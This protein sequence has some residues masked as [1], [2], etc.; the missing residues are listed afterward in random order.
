MHEK[1]KERNILIIYLFIF[2][3]VFNRSICFS[4]KTNKYVWYNLH[5]CS[6]LAENAK[7]EKLPINCYNASDRETCY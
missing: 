2:V 3:V 6:L 4:S 5:F 7:A 1:G